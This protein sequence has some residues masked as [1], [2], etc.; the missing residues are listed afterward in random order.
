MNAPKVAKGV[1]SR[2]SSESSSTSSAGS[3]KKK[4]KGKKLKPADR[5]PSG[6]E[7]LPKTAGVVQITTI[8]ASKPRP[9]VAQVRG[10]TPETPSDVRERSEARNA[11]M[12]VEHPPAAPSSGLELAAVVQ[13]S[14]SAISVIPISKPILRQRTRH[15]RMLQ[16]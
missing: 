16:Q 15:G 6:G 11:P 8:K 3:T 2:G 13:T 1:H 9:A 10:E 14:A 5:L 7:K 12:P 4:G